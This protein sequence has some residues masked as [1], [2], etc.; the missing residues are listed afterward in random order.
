MCWNATGTHLLSGSDDRRF[1]ITRVDATSATYY[2]EQDIQSTH[3]H[4]IFAARFLPAWDMSHIVS[5]SAEGLVGY[6]TV[7]RKAMQQ[8]Q[9]HTELVYD[10]HV[11]P[12]SAATFL[13]CSGD[14]TVR[15]FDVRQ[16][17]SCECGGDDEHHVLINTTRLRPSMAVTAISTNPLQPYYLATACSDGYVR[18]YDRRSTTEQCVSMFAPD[19]VLSN[20]VSDEHRM[21]ALEYDSTGTE[22]LLSYSDHD[23][24]LFNVDSTGTRTTDAF[25]SSSDDS[26]SNSDG[27]DAE[28]A[29]VARRRARLERAAQAEEHAR[30]EEQLQ[31]ERE[32]QEHQERQHPLDALTTRLR[33]HRR[34]DNETETY[35]TLA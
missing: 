1:L 27:E 10:V 16:A 3:M 11:M 9:C 4:N 32:H 25:G 17:T 5:C 13:S 7:E 19:A 28:Q 35:A 12:A 33:E 6:T 18:I 14:G 21:T 8:F 15:E 31:R 20:D 26:I 29:D 2:V 34:R 23:L 30:D 22:L 24:F